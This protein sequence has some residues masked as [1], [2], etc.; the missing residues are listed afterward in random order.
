MNLTREKYEEYQ[1]IAKELNFE[2]N[3]LSDT[4]YEVAVQCCNGIGPEWFPPILRDIIDA[5]HPSLIIDS[6]NHDINW[7]KKHKKSAEYFLASNKAF[8]VNGI[9]VAKW[10]YCCIN[11]LRYWVIHKAKQSHRLLNKYGEKAYNKACE[12]AGNDDATASAIDF[13]Q[14]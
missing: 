14:S 8:E 3:D 9:K 5:L 6:L 4:P 1:R 13:P 2:M 10:R 7:S 12:E 11:P